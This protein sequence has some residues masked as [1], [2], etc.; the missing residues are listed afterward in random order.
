[1]AMTLLPPVDNPKMDS[2]AVPI[3]NRTEGIGGDSHVLA[4]IGDVVAPKMT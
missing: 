4:K 1:M 2:V 3:G